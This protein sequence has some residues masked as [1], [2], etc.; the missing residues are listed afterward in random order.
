M[1][2]IETADGTHLYSKVW[3]EG[4]P[5]I[6][7]HGWPLSGDSWDPI[8]HALADAGLKAIAYDR[9]G[10][11]RSSQ[12]SGGYDYDTFADDLA[13]VMKHYGV[14]ENAALVGFSM[15]GGE[16]ARYMSRHGGKGV[17]QAVLISSVVP[18]ML[19]EDNNPD[20]V[21]QAT[22]D[23]MTQGMLEDRAKFFT[24]FFKDFFGMGMLAHPVSD[25]VLHL[26]WAT[27]MQAGL[28]PTLGAAKA[29]ATTDFRPDL[30]HFRVPTLVIHGTADKTVPIAATGHEVARRVDSARLIEYDGEP[31]GL[32]ATQ[33]ERLKSDLL[34]FLL[35][36]EAP[37]S[38]EALDEMTREALVLPQL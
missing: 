24:G 13:A 12:P 38:Q 6:L 8:S 30:P 17:S 28:R 18:Y 3:G 1:H 25:E 27:A 4:R 9:R 7:I 26:A 21:P 29:F 33:T 16:I 35:G 31:H 23:Q 14:T 11:G 37:R 10:F 19:K 22:F 5:V 15:G 2:I 20:G 34:A 32:F 36:E